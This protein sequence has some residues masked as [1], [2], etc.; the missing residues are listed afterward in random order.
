MTRERLFTKNVA[1]ADRATF[2]QNKTWIVRTLVSVFVSSH[3]DELSASDPDAQYLSISGRDEWT[4]EKLNEALQSAT[5]RPAEFLGRGDAGGIEAGNTADLILLDAN[6]AT[7]IRNIKNIQA[8][9]V[10][11][12]YLSRSDI[13][14]MLEVRPRL[15]EAAPGL[16]TAVILKAALRVC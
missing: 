5:I 2:R 14:H 7:D 4:P 6:P 9:F 16:G 8:V 15:S 1:V 13:D 3:L 11:G 12:R 10:K